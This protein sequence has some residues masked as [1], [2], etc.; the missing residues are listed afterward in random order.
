MLDFDDFVNLSIRIM[1][2]IE[3]E[4]I[5]DEIISSRETN[6]KFRKNDLTIQI[7]MREMYIG[8]ELYIECLDS[9]Y[10]HCGFFDN[11]IKATKP[12]T[13]EYEEQKFDEIKICTEKLLY[14]L[15]KI[16]NKLNLKLFD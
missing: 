1:N 11:V 8:Y 10:C 5:K 3:F 12:K 16:S 2:E 15:C 4:L 6:Y 7:T 13:P 14:I 9:N